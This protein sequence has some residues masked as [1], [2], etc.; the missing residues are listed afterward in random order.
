MD[1]PHYA[2]AYYG[3]LNI[4]NFIIKNSFQNTLKTTTTDC[5]YTPLHI[6]A[7]K[8]HLEVCKLLFKNMEEKNPLDSN[9]K[10]PLH[11]ASEN[12]HWKVVHYLIIANKL[13]I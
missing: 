11:L 12:N 2:A 10:T 3:K 4:C 8:G 7:K 13:H 9:G 1:I 5:E 6:A